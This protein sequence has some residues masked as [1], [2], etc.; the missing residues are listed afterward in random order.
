MDNW[1]VGMYFVCAAHAVTAAFPLLQ[2]S[3]SPQLYLW[4]KPE[5]VVLFPHGI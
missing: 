5:G 3:H 1:D 4:L 2:G